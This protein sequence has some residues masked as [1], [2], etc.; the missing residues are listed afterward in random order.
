MLVIYLQMVG[1]DADKTKFEQL[2][3][4]YRGLMFYIAQEILHNEQDSEDAVHQAFLSII[5]N[6]SKISGVNC[7]KTRAFVVI[8][9]ERKAIDI[10]RH[11]AKT[12]ETDNEEIVGG[13]EL[14]LPGDGGLADAMARL[15]GRYREI[16]LLRY[17]HGYS[18]REIAPLLGVKQTTAQKILWRAKEALRKQMEGDGN[19]ES[20]RG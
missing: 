7:P 17:Y 1:N 3:M 9:T 2:Y 15:P 5:E 14:P 13:M 8:I 11:R 6:M 10:L 18:V 20:Q 19:D 16:I 12:V 4:R